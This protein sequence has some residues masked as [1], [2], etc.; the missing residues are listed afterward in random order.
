MIITLAFQ[1]IPDDNIYS[2]IFSFL[3]KLITKSKYSHVEVFFKSSGLFVS[4]DIRTGVVIK[5]LNPNLSNKY[6]Y[7]DIEF[8]GRKYKNLEKYLCSINNSKYDLK[9]I[10]L[11][12]L[13]HLKSKKSQSNKKFFCSELV[14]N[15]LKKLGLVLDK[16]DYEYSPELLYRELNAKEII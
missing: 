4:S 1:K 5:Q 3:I 7:F 9:G 13:L 6:D 8:D 15:I 2:K 14:S 12:Q 11:S 16:Q 10:F